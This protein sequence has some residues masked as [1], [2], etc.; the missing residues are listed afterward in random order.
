MVAVQT[1]K[2]RLQPEITAGLDYSRIWMDLRAKL[3]LFAILISPL[4]MA[5]AADEDRI[6]WSGNVGYTYRS[7]TNSENPTNDTVSNQVRGTLNAS[8]YIWQPW[9][10]MTQANITMT[11]DDTQFDNNTG[12]LTTIV[13][14]DL[15]LGILPRSRTPFQLSYRASD[16]RV[17]G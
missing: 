2:H 8:T 12:S 15:D 5:H 9:F 1:I 14:G 6:D 11:Q 10:A 17:D 13:T 7:L 3:A 4:S 16:S